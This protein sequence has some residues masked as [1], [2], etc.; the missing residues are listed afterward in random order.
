MHVCM[1]TLPANNIDREGGGSISMQ[2]SP[3]AIC[4]GDVGRGT[5][6]LR[7]LYQQWGAAHEATAWLPPSPPP[8]PT[9]RGMMWAKWGGP[10][11]SS[12][13]AVNSGQKALRRVN[14]LLRRSGGEGC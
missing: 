10:L 4:R 3:L 12:W 11:E 2:V 8:T 14:G 9:G 7:F 1:H 6:P 5:C 13:G